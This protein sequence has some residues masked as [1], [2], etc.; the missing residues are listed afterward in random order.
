MPNVFEK[1]G[2][3]FG[4]SASNEVEEE[5]NDFFEGSDYGEEAEQPASPENESGEFSGEDGAPNN[6]INISDE[7]N[8]KFVL[9]K[10][11]TFS[12]APNIAN[13][14]IKH[15][16]IILNFEDTNKDE[17]RRISDFLA[18]VAYAVSGS[19]KKVATDTLIVMP[20]NVSLTGD[21]IINEVGTDSIYFWLQLF[22]YFLERNSK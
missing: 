7:H 13:E 3:R 22:T 1:L 21:D 16:T 8:I 5:P 2:G 12:D 18:G 17:A 15:N 19:V 10:P 11:E 4:F 6:V 9:F 14:L 20:S